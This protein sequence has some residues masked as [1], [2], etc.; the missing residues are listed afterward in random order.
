ML[1]GYE[2]VSSG[3]PIFSK[4]RGSSVFSLHHQLQVSIRK[5][6]WGMIWDSTKFVCITKSKWIFSGKWSKDSGDSWGRCGRSGRHTVGIASAMPSL[7]PWGNHSL[8]PWRGRPL[9][10]WGVHVSPLSPGTSFSC[11]RNGIVTVI[12]FLISLPCGNMSIQANVQGV[13][14]N[15]IFFVIAKNRKQF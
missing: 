4:Q 14:K 3:C 6:A 7:Q 1:D 13:F 10:H 8:W 15:C 11:L 9:K 12:L 2:A 5:L